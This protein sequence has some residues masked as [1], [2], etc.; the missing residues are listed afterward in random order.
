MLKGGLRK[1][2]N[3][4]SREQKRERDYGSRTAG[5]KCGGRRTEPMKKGRRL[6]GISILQ[7]EKPFDMPCEVLV[8]FGVS[9][10]RLSAPVGRVPIDVVP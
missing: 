1:S 4:E 10:H 6:K 8:N 2:R 5:P 7:A 9:G 3:W